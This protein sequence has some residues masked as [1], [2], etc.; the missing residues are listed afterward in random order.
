MINLIPGDVRGRGEL[1]PY[2]RR[3]GHESVPCHELC[4]FPQALNP[5]P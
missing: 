5:K 4:G 1:D 3:H 2:L